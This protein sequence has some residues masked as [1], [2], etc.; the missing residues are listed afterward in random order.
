LSSFFKG[1][2][3]PIIFRANSQ[4]LGRGGIKGLAI[5]AQSLEKQGRTVVAAV[6]RTP[7]QL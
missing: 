7:F 4:F 3:E 1:D 5:T 2:H 6:K